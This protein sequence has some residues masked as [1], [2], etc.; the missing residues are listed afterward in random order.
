MQHWC[1]IA[2]PVLV[3]QSRPTPVN[4]IGR[5]GF[6]IREILFAV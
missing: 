1:E 3:N 6:V 2:K 4:L 5:L